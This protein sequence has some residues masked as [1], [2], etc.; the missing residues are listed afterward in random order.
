MFDPWVEKN[1]LEEENDNLLQYSCLKKSHG[2]RTL[3]GSSLKAPK[4]S[5]V[6]VIMHA[7]KNGY[8]LIQSG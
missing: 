3:V 5:D 6:T 4:E 1:P 7:L 8:S 2:Q